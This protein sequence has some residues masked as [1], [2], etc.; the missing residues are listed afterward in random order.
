[1][2]IPALVFT[3]N[4]NPSATIGERFLDGLIRDALELTR[5]NSRH[6]LPGLE[7]TLHDELT[8]AKSAQEKDAA[9]RKFAKNANGLMAA[10]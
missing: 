7:P 3:L 9:L 2:N 4:E 10:R 6:A 1:M 5:P 8:R